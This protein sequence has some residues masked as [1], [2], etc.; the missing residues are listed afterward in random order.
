MRPHGPS[1]ASRALLASPS[2][3][4]RPKGSFFP[5]LAM[6]GTTGGHGRSCAL[7]SVWGLAC[8]E[9]WRPTWVSLLYCFALIFVRFESK[10]LPSTWC[11]IHSCPPCTQ[12]RAGPVGH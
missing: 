1:P 6:S 9:V 7:S 10:L 5:A 4:A 3:V 11:M 8:S 12:Q 2:D